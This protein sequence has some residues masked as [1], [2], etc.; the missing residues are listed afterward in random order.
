MNYLKW[1][2]LTVTRKSCHLQELVDGI[3]DDWSFAVRLPTQRGGDMRGEV[4]QDLHVDVDAH[5]S[6]DG[7]E[8]GVGGHDGGVGAASDTDTR[9]SIKG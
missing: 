3:A 6:G 5:P 8:Q 7:D 4:V 9:F 2:E 1:A